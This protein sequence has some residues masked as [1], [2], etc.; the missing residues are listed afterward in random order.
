MTRVFEE[1]PEQQKVIGLFTNTTSGAGLNGSDPG[2]GKTIMAVQTLVNRK[3]KRA[4][5][6]APPSTF[7]NWESTLKT[8]SG[9]ELLLCANSKTAGRTVAELQRN[10]A[11]VQAGEDGWYFVSRE[12][13]NRQN[14]KQRTSGGKPVRTSKGKASMSRVDIWCRKKPFDAAVFDEVQMCSDAKARTRQ[15]WAN[16]NAG[17]KLAQSADWFGTNLENMYTVTH[18]LWPGF[19]GLNRAEWVDEY[20]LTEFDPFSYTKKKA[21]GEQ[22]PGFFASTLPCYAAL[23]SPIEKPV[24]E[25]RWVDML[26]AQRKLYDKLAQDMAAEIDGDILVV[27]MPMTLSMR[28]KELALG[29][30]RPVDVMRKDKE[31]GEDKPG[32]TVA[33]DPGAPSAKIDEIKAIMRDHP[34]EPVIILTSSSKFA[35]KAAIDLDGLPYTGK[36]T[37]E[38]K[39]ANRLAFINGETKVLIG[40][41]AMSE[42]LDGLQHVCHVGIIA[43]R[44]SVPYKNTQFLGRIARRG[45]KRRVVAYELIARDTVDAGIVHKSIE[46]IL[47]NNQAKA[48]QKQKEG[49]E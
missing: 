8:V 25:K 44:V 15:T 38:E 45:Q 32:Q 5:I 49:P 24:P 22:W 20:L 26:P 29:M 36:Q 3:A 17:F 13:F 40:T 14:W 34:G 1:D 7:E 9:Q 11:A 31:T 39:D 28:L 27:E 47:Q 42:G 35:N 6:V 41:E 19:S 33:F 16:L 23:Q 10:L 18:D 48:I 43:S 4:L 21:V 12:L 37:P 2:V 30:F 46:R